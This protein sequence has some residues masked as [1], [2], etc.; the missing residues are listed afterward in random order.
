M[1]LSEV[2]QELRKYTKY[3]T[4]LSDAKVASSNQNAPRTLKPFI[5]IYINAIR[6]VGTPVKQEINDAGI[7]RLTTQYLATASFNAF[8]DDLHEAEELLHKVRSMFFTQLQYEI[9]QGKVVFLRV[10]RGVDAVPKAL[11]AQTE[12]QAILD[13]EISYVD[14]VEYETGFIETIKI[15]NEINDTDIIIE[16]S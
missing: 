13:V 14:S 9:L 5:K 15:H 8:S 4:G 16:R 1:M 10:L 6:N 2:Y 12:S 3:V 11:N 7:E